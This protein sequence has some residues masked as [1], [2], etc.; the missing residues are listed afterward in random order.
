MLLAMA[1]V[2]FCTAINAQYAHE[3]SLYGGGGLSTLNYSVTAGRQ[4]SGSGGAFGLGY[5]FFFSKNFGLGTGAELALYN[6][7]YTLDNLSQQYMTVDMEGTDFEFR[8]AITNYDEKQR[9]LLLQIPLMLQ[10]QTGSKRQFYAA[11]G[12]RAGIPLSGK[13][14]SSSATIVNSG[15]YP[16]ENYEYTTQEFM[17]F[18]TFTDRSANNDLNFKTVFF[19]STEAG[20]KWKLKNKLTLYTGAYLDY[21][22]NNIYKENSP[23]QQFTAYNTASPRDFTENSILASQYTQNDNFQSFTEKITPLAVGIKVKLAFGFGSRVKKAETPTTEP[24]Q[25]IQALPAAVDS[26]AFR[27]AQLAARLAAKKAKA[28]SAAQTQQAEIARQQAAAAQ[29]QAV[30]TEIQQPI[31]YYE[32][33]QTELTDAQKQL[34]DEKIA[35]LQQNPKLKVFIYGHTCDLGGDKINEDV[36]LQRAQKAK[37]YLLSKG[38]DEDRILGIASKRD[39]EPLAPNDSEEN[40]RQNRRVELIIYVM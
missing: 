7:K 13:S 36:G 19:A 4:N 6:A 40:R 33:A 11:L 29:L 9:A 21:G 15:Y 38:I 8:S 14:E 22:L 1:G 20:V 23:A 30:K 26:M 12:G 16:V 32:L 24:T 27:A 18:G 2:F 39:T 10:F 35:L 5:Q 34:L 28:D 31:Q 25:P 37:A 3:L 17:G